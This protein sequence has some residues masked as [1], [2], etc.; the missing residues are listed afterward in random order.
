MPYKSEAQ[1]RYFNSPA[2]KEKIGEE[3]VEHWNEV[4]KGKKLPEKAIDKAI[5][6]CDLRVAFPTL[7]EAIEYCNENGIGKQAIVP[8]GSSFYVETMK[9]KES[10][11]FHYKADK[12]ENHGKKQVYIETI[13]FW[14]EHQNPSDARASK[15]WEIAR[16]QPRVSLRNCTRL[17]R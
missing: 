12:Y 7:Q 1:R 16:R 9:A 3:E 5:R 11:M 17:D 10:P 8:S 14:D 2:G 4:S 13:E 6:A 15:Q